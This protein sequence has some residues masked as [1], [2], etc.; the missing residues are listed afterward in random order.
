MVAHEIT[1]GLKDGIMITKKD[2][3]TKKE[4]KFVDTHNLEV[5]KEDVDTFLKSLS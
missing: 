5:V 2:E 1:L 4:N 3:L